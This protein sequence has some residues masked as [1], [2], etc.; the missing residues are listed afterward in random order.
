VG[1]QLRPRLQPQGPQQYHLATLNVL[2]R[3]CPTTLSASHE[4][5]S[6]L[7]PRPV[8]SA[9][10]SPRRDTVW[11]EIDEVLFKGVYTPMCLL[12]FS[13]KVG[14]VGAGPQPLSNDGRRVWK[15][16]PVHCCHRRCHRHQ[17][18]RRP[19]QRRKTQ[20]QTERKGLQNILYFCYW[21]AVVWLRPS[22]GFNYVT[23]QLVH[24]TYI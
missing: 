1:Q 8:R 7:L 14:D 19:S 3:S 4:P 13:E 10:N 17:R 20:G 24:S 22:T 9:Q 18:L 16:R 11:S 5:V 21:F 12:L 15:D 2:G 23:Q 6:T